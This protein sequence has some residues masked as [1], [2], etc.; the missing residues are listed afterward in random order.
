MKEI[1]A[2]VGT[3]SELAR[4]APALRTIRDQYA[5]V[6][7]PRLMHT[8]EKP[9]MVWSTGALFGLV[10]DRQHALSEDTMTLADLS[11]QIANAVGHELDSRAT[12]LVIVQGNSMTAVLAGQQA[13]LRQIPVVHVDS[14]ASRLAEVASIAQ[15][16]RR[17]LSAISSFRCV[18]DRAQADEL[19]HL[20]YPAYEV[21]VT[22][23]SAVE[24]AHL[25]L[26][27]GHDLHTNGAASGSEPNVD[28][29]VGLKDEE[30]SR[31]SSSELGFAL[32]S[33]A[34]DHPAIKI[35]VM[36]PLEK[37]GKG[38]LLS[39]LGALKN[40][41]LIAPSDYYSYLKALAGAS[42]VLTNSEDIAE[43]ALAVSR[44]VVLMQMEAHS[45]LQGG[46]LHMQAISSTQDSIVNAVEMTV[47]E[48][49]GTNG[50]GFASAN[51]SNGNGYGHHHSAIGDGKASLR[52]VRLLNNWAR[53]RV[54]T[55]HA[56]EPYDG[57]FQSERGVQAEVSTPLMQ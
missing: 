12:D 49:R 50:N 17:M 38:L 23:S 30:T 57:R 24:A 11:W 10:P 44:P 16:N 3:R 7:R 28:L 22:G 55:S 48:H 53:N 9:Q 31:E 56:F 54:L 46:G 40:V 35:R 43:E 1:L 20:G 51:G 26:A 52:I 37:T 2:V 39:I 29:F 42:V 41:E 5:T 14:L 13:F 25:V 18:P 34:H 36:C 21:G 32:A 19:R 33:L 15:S 45:P 6:M 47:A 27:N 4:L 8:G